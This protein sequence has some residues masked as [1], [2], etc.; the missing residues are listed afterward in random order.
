MSD[1]LDKK[2]ELLPNPIWFPGMTV[3]VTKV[4]GFPF[5]AFHLE[6]AMDHS[7]WTRLVRRFQ[8][9]GISTSTALDSPTNGHAIGYVPLPIVEEEE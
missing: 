2:N 3:S 6:T 7:R 4:N 8:E 5:L 1:Y 9:F